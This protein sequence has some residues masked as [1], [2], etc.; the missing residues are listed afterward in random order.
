MRDESDKRAKIVA[1]ELTP[2]CLLARAVLRLQRLDRAYAFSLT[3]VT[4]ALTAALDQEREEKQ[5]IAA[6]TI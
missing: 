1:D 3:E 2:F 4:E 5:S 6:I